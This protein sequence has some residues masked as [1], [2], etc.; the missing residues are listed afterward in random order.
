ML[1]CTTAFFTE[2]E[3]LLTAAACPR[4]IKLR[5]A[6]RYAAI[7]KGRLISLA[8]SGV[9]RG[10]AVVLDCLDNEESRKILCRSAVKQNIP[11][12]YG[13]VCGWTGIIMTV[14]NSSCPWCLTGQ[15]YAIE[16]KSILGATCG[17]I[18]SM[19][20]LEAIKVITGKGEPLLNRTLFWK[21]FTSTTIEIEVSKDDM[22][23][24]CGR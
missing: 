4:W 9:I 22:C 7:G 16:E 24:V 23:P 15:G 19:Q 12:V 10:A 3:Y 17:I 20:A 5:E 13:A 21:G 6:T 2:N 18:G 14:H 8:V 1:R 11:L